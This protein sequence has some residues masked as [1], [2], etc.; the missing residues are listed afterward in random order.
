MSFCC[1]IWRTPFGNQEVS[2]I[3]K[4]SAPERSR[5]IRRE[6]PEYL[7]MRGRVLKY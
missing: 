1:E 7:S 4:V 6:I 2:I 5:Q 3:G